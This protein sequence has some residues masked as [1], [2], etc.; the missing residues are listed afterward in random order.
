MLIDELRD[1]YRTSLTKTCALFGMSR[2]LYRYRYRYRSAAR[3]S[4]ALLMR[5]KEITATRVHDGDRCVHVVLRGNA[6]E[7][8]TRVYRRYRAEGLLLSLI[9]QGITRIDIKGGVGAFFSAPFFAAD[10]LFLARGS[11]SRASY[12]RE[13]GRRSLAEGGITQ[14]PLAAPPSR[15]REALCVALIAPAIGFDCDHAVKQHKALVYRRLEKRVG[16]PMCACLQD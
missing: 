5:I 9:P 14:K 15:P 10:R 12:R 7:T 3:D 11:G 8:I 13:P 1:R 16:G 4:S 6:G 2:S